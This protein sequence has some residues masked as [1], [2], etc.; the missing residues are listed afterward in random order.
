[1]NFL[2]SEK[3]ESS[4]LNVMIDLFLAGMETTSSSLLWS[5]FYLLHHPECQGKIHDEINA[6]IGRDRL[7]SLEDKPK[8]DYTNAFM[9]EAMR[10]TAFVPMSVFHFTYSEIKYKGYTIPP[11]TMLVSSLYHVLHDPDYFPEPE[12]FR[13]ER[14]LDSQGKFKPDERVVPFGIGKRYC[15]GKSLAEKE[16][17]LFFVGLMQGFE[18]SKVPGT[19]LP[20][21]AVK[22]VP[23]IGLTRNVPEYEIILTSR[24]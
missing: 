8:L 21:Y 2:Y 18:V 24:E 9:H 11:D 10:C 13:P 12:K 17:F 19:T 14:F 3:G 22:D 23:V 15:L 4:L 6:H 5:F 20:S 16:Y 1:M 7:P